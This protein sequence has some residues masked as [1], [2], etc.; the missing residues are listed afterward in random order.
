[1]EFSCY[2]FPHVEFCAIFLCA[3]VFPVVFSACGISYFIFLRVERT[4]VL[5]NFV[6]YFSACG[7]RSG[8][9]EF[10]V[11]FFCVWNALWY[12]GISCYIFMRASRTRSGIVEFCVIF[13]RVWNAL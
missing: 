13:F 3:L 10:R 11:I 6:L 4:L 7:T 9:V 12:C 2:N 5:L 8:I 1:M